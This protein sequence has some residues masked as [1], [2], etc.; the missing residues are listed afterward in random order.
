MFV[1]RRKGGTK[2]GGKEDQVAGAE[3]GL[4]AGLSLRHAGRW[5]SLS[6]P[7]SIAHSNWCPQQVRLALYC[8]QSISDTRPHGIRCSTAGARQGT[9]VCDVNNIRRPG[10]LSASSLMRT[11]PGASTWVSVCGSA[12]PRAGA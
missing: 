9:Q 1:K 6:S 11:M 10:L 12:G 5:E 2:E 4:H 3:L 7:L 8:P